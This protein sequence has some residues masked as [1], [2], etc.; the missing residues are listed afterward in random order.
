[1]HIEAFLISGSVYSELFNRVSKSLD[2][3]LNNEVSRQLLED[4]PVNTKTDMVI[5]SAQDGIISLLKKWPNMRSKLIIYFNQP[6]SDVLRPVAW[7]AFL[8]NAKGNECI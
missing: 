5:E 6:L 1:M 8:E 4:F 2:R 3:Q 7:K